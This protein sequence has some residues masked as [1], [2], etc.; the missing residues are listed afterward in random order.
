[1]RYNSARHFHCASTFCLSLTSAASLSR[2]R[3]QLHYKVPV[4]TNKGCVCE[5]GR[6]TNDN[7]QAKTRNCI[8]IRGE[9]E[10]EPNLLFVIIGLALATLQ[11]LPI[12]QT[13]AKN[14]RSCEFPVRAR[15]QTENGI[16]RAH[17]ADNDS[18]ACVYLEGALAQTGGDK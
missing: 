3:L 16:C 2:R 13:K 18:F 12:M 5:C 1:M 11:N 7:T 10:Q 9:F 6:N 15:V 4:S 8:P 14:H 17:A